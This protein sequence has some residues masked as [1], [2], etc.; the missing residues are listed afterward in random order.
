MGH[1]HN[2]KIRGGGSECGWRTDCFYIV[3]S[4]QQTLISYYIIVRYPRNLKISKCSFSLYISSDG[5]SIILVL[6]SMHI[7]LSHSAYFHHVK[8]LMKQL[9]YLYIIYHYITC[10]GRSTQKCIP[11]LPTSLNKSEYATEKSHHLDI[12]KSRG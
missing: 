1:S 8:W 9:K 11:I 2:N 3:F 6:L 4:L 5:E 7:P 10:S 12:T